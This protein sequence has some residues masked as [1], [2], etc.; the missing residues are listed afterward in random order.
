M[1][2]GALGSVQESELVVVLSPR[3]PDPFEER[4]GLGR[5]ACQ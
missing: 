4:V 3:R 1:F 5:S 2:G